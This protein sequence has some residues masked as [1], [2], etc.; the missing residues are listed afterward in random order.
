MGLDSVELLVEIER[1]FDIRIPDPVAEKMDTVGK[2]YDEVWKRIQHRNSGKFILQ[3][4]FYRLRAC[5][6]EELT[7]E[8]NISPST[9]ID[10]IVPK[11][12]RRKI[13]AIL[14]QRSKLKLPEL[15]L[16]DKI[17]SG[18]F[19]WGLVVFCTI[20]WLSWYLNERLQIGGLIYL[21]AIAVCIAIMLLSSGILKPQRMTIPCTTMRELTLQ[22]LAMNMPALNEQGVTR[23]EMEMIIN[24]VIV[25]IMGINPAEIA[26]EKSFGNDLGLN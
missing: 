19:K 5:F 20:T 17:A 8:I 15:V 22:V 2:A 11:A 1:T 10:D 21:L 24:N 16:P 3:V 26:P 25:E 6:K 9:L 12:D 23:K 4:L 14:S 13:W 18:L 7:V